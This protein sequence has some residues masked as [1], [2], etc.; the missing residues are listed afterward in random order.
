LGITTGPDGKLWFAKG[1]NSSAIGTF[2]PFAPNKVTEYKIP[3]ASVS[4]WSTGPATTRSGSPTL[5]TAPWDA[6]NCP[7]RWASPVLAAYPASPA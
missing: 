5:D 6:F 2:S 4:A 3:G 1:F 7:D